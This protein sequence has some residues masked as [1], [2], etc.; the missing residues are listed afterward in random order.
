MPSTRWYAEP[1][2]DHHCCVPRLMERD[3]S[4]RARLL[5]GP[6][7]HEG[8]LEKPRGTRCSTYRRMPLDMQTKF[9]AF[10]R[11]SF[12][13][14][15]AL[16]QSKRCPHHRRESDSNRCDRRF[17]RDLNTRLTVLSSAAALRERRGRHPELAKHFSNS[18]AR[19]ACVRATSG[20]CALLI[21]Y[22]CP[23]TPRARE[24]HA[25]QPL[26]RTRVRCPRSA[27]AC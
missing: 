5:H 16:T 13:R 25:R 7:R 21:R 23:A 12:T 9:C 14:S 2:L 17:R 27:A 3:F 8:S 18:R 24:R 10:S 20:A 15:A 4:G 6:Q 11:Q 26:S 22:P 1:S 19:T